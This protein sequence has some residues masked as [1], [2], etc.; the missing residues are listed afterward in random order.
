MGY[1]G[2][3]SVTRSGIAC[4]SWSSQCPHRH[5]RTPETYPELAETS[6]SCRNPGGQGPEGPWCY[7]TDPNVR[8]EYCDVAKCRTVPAPGE[9]PVCDVTR[10]STC[11]RSL[12]LIT[13]LG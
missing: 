3:V 7:T 13:R 8:W 12:K 5:W 1:R 9:F 10:Q 4:Q 6:N 11:P 2:D